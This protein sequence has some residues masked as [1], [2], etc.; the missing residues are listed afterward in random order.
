MTEIISTLL[1]ATG[2]ALFYMHKKKK[3]EMEQARKILSKRKNTLKTI[4][5]FLKVEKKLI[6]KVKKYDKVFINLF[7]EQY[8]QKSDWLDLE[9]HIK[10]TNKFK[11]SKREDLFAI[12]DKDVEYWQNKFLENE[13]K[14]HNKFFDKVENNP[15]TKKQRES[16]MVME[17][18]NLI[19]AGAGTGKTS[20]MVGR[21]GYLVNYKKNKPSEILMLTFTRSGAAEMQ[22]RIN[23]KLG[24]NIGERIKIKTFHSLSL[25]ISDFNLRENLIFTDDE[26]RD[27]VLNRLDK[28][29]KDVNEYIENLFYKEK[30]ENDFHD[31]ESYFAYIHKEEIKTYKNE[32]VKSHSERR[33]ANWLAQ[34]GIKYKY[35]E[36]FVNNQGDKIIRNGKHIRYY[37]DFYLPDYGIWIE[38]FG[39][40]SKGKTRKDI[41]T[42]K[43]KE[44][45]E[46]K[47]NLH[48]LHNTK[49]ID[50][51]FADVQD[52]TLF[53]KLEYKLKQ[54][55]VEFNEKTSIEVWGLIKESYVYNEFVELV[56]NLIALIKMKIFKDGAKSIDELTMIKDMVFFKRIFND[57]NKML[58]E[59]NK[60]DFTDMVLNGIDNIKNGKYKK[61]YKHILVDEFQDTNDIQA[62]LI[63]L[64]RDTNK[65]SVLCC[66]GD[67]WQSIYRFQGGN[68]SLIT[69]FKNKF[70][71]TSIVKLD[72]AFRFNKNILTVA[73]N[74]IMEN[75]K[76][77][78]KDMDT[79]DGI[80][81]NSIVI[82]PYDCSGYKEN[83]DYILSELLRE[84]IKTIRDNDKI[85]KIMILTRNNRPFDG[86]D[87]T[88]HLQKNKCEMKTIH[89]SKGL[90]AEYVIMLG[91]DN[92][93]YGIPN[94][95]EEKKELFD[96]IPP[97][98][99]GIKYADER[100]LFYVALTRAK[101]KVYLL[102][103]QYKPS[104][105]I[106]ELLSEKYKNYIN[107]G[108]FKNIEKNHCPSC[109]SIRNRK[110]GKG[111]LSDYW[112][113]YNKDCI[114]PL[115]SIK[116]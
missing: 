95:R 34:K 21:A 1:I 58:K 46:W 86:K 25:E 3:K 41:D 44:N 75:P 4:D 15:L 77:L 14:K 90:E 84:V 111:N 60:I 116:K 96:L 71:D 35:E 43:Y 29:Y 92:D 28:Y 51:Y 62:D 20:V 106:D 54:F 40:D 23:N 10:I 103:N 100:R 113:C 2:S 12:Y 109:G 98:C 114:E 52:K 22:D 87:F 110:K 101:K 79:I 76:Q 65:N 7:N 78:K 107:C 89:S 93:W 39:L 45:K 37:P 64:L 83:R 48:R 6:R 24:K 26:K 97:E 108:K 32:R 69:D 112:Q 80:K 19:L 81:N 63:K 85:G 88:K 18:N 91:V 9:R 31:K 102:T 49:F 16:C 61:N 36:E 8:A 33:I 94:K 115:E 50:L 74:F 82:L 68:V 11:K 57:Y 42:N 17:K 38:F 5:N 105:Y 13:N 73:N 99:D 55:E 66:V 53:K 70:G 72:K 30:T 59:E 104:E 47:I 27:F 56:I 67:D